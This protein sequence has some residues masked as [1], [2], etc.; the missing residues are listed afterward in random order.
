MSCPSENRLLLLVIL[1]T[2]FLTSSAHECRKHLFIYFQ[3]ILFIWNIPFGE[4][5]LFLPHLC[6][7]RIKLRHRNRFSVL[8][9][10][11]TPLEKWIHLSRTVPAFCWQMKAQILH[12][13][14]LSELK[15]F[16]SVLCLTTLKQTCWLLFVLISANLD[17]FFFSYYF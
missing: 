2:I 3:C 4:G 7:V 9:H 12:Y 8:S 11:L 13:S 15:M 14:H 5:Q 1:Q 17:L 10:T 16:V 6:N